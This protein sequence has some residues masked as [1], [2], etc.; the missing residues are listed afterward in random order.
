MSKRPSLSGMGL[1]RHVA[2]K[3]E[4]T[5]EQ[6]APAPAEPA[7]KLRHIQVRLT[8]AGWEQLKML[9]I[10]ERRS[11]QALMVEALNDLLRKYSRAPMAAGPA[12]E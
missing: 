7:G 2:P 8:D 10:S 11:A 9:T 1:G 4:P 12:D 6:S 5:A 3:G